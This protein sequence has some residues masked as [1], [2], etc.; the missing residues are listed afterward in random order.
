MDVDLDNT[1]RFEIGW[2]VL[3]SQRTN[4]EEEFNY[5]PDETLSTI[6]T[7]DLLIPDKNINTKE[8]PQRLK[9]VM[10]NEIANTLKRRI[11]ANT[12][13]N[14]SFAMKTYAKW[15][16]FR[17][18]PP[19]TALDAYG[20]QVPVDFTN[21]DYRTIDYWL[22]IFVL[23]AR[24]QDGKPYPPNTLYNIIAAG[25]ILTPAYYARGA[26]ASVSDAR[27]H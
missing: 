26:H 3:N 27:L 13:S 1:A 10:Q 21:T 12:S 15:A 19:E 6:N 20:P 7:E 18:K 5:L 11:P 14:S 8:T 2:S 4:N 22:G 23:E 24:R 25:F 16:E 17:N 9:V